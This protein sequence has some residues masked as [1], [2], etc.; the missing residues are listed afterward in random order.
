MGPAADHRDTAW[1]L[2][3]RAVA[4]RLAPG[5]TFC[6]AYWLEDLFNWALTD[7]DVGEAG[8]STYEEEF[9][10]PG[11]RHVGVDYGG[12]LP[13]RA[14]LEGQAS[15]DCGSP[16][17]ADCACYRDRPKLSTLSPKLKLDP[18]GSERLA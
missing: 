3:R 17:A 12:P 11:I 16:L 9:R 4:A 5:W 14:V 18:N 7:D 10:E 1:R 8:F 2:G 6:S 15:H 13:S